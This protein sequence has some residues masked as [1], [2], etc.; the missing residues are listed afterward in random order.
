MQYRSIS[1]LKAKV[2]PAESLRIIESAKDPALVDH[3]SVEG[4]T[5]ASIENT[6][7]PES[8]E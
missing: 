7:S 2:R 8:T 1:G 3:G 4:K 6:G 5:E